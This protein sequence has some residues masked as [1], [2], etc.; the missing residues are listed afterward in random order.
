LGTHSVT[1]FLTFLLDQFYEPTSIFASDS[2]SRVAGTFGV[3]LS[4]Q[5]FLKPATFL[6]DVDRQIRMAYAGRRAD[7]PFEE[8]GEELDKTEGA[9]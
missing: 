2:G 4:P 3:T 9:D 7:F 6:I 8:V 1:P 5:E